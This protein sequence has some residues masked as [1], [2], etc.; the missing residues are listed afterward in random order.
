MSSRVSIAIPMAS[1]VLAAACWGL[2]T[3]LSKAALDHLPP[4]TLLVTQLVASLGLL[5]LVLSLQRVPWRWSRQLLPVSLLGWLN[6]GVSYTLSLIGLSLTTASMSALLWA[7]EPLLIAGLA[8][9][10]LRERLTARFLLLG[11]LA[12]AGVVLVV[13][14]GFAGASQLVGNTLILGGVGCCA[15]YTVLARR[16][17]EG[18]RPLLAVALQLGL[19]LVWALMIWPLELRHMTLGGLAQVP[20][21]AWLLAVVSGVVYYGLAFWFFLAG[22]QC[23]R[24]SEAGL[25]INLVPLFALAGAYVLLG[26]TLRPVQWLGSGL[27]LAAVVGLSLQTAAGTPAGVPEAG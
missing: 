25:M 20:T 21:A 10:L 2:G 8:W 9:L 11:G 1:L 7:M 15:L 3:A 6:P 24:A 26:E 22:L 13:G 23:V 14:T 5:W 4:L 19:A 16:T 12:A 27:V 17:G 18:V